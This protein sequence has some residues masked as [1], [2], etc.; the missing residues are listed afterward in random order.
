MKVYIWYP[1]LSTRQ[2]GHAALTLDDG[3]HISWWPS[4][5]IEGKKSKKN[6]R[7]IGSLDEDI[8]LEGRSPDKTFTIPGLDEKAIKDW[9]ETF[10]DADNK[11]HLAERNC[12]H[13]V[14]NALKAGGFKC[15]EYTEYLLKPATVE[16][17]VQAGVGVAV[18][19]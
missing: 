7:D 19:T 12:C 5:K 18:I 4:D 13:I 16:S 8:K 6:P 1:R 11:Y 9:W 17:L 2:V 14:M 15:K 10:L 3:T